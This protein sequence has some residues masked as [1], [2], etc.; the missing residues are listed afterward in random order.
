M[1]SP[2]FFDEFVPRVRYLCDQIYSQPDVDSRKKYYSL[3]LS[4][5]ESLVQ[6]VASE[7]QQ[8]EEATAAASS[9]NTQDLF[10]EF[11]ESLPQTFVGDDYVVSS[12]DSTIDPLR[13]YGSG[14]ENPQVP[15][16]GVAASRHQAHSAPPDVS[17]YTT[18]PMPTTASKPLPQASAQ[19]REGVTSST[20]DEA[21]DISMG[22]VPPSASAPIL[23]ISSSG[24]PGPS[25]SHTGL[26][27]ASASKTEANDCCEICGY[28][29][30]GDPQW[31]KGSMAKHKKL[32]HSTDPPV[33][34]RCPFPGCTSAYKN[35]QDN[36]RQHQLEKGHFVGDEA[37]SRR[38]SKRKKV[39]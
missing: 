14:P 18:S 4:L 26:P 30:K 20:Q 10:D 11:I 16:M 7:P 37:A 23:P 24:L 25:T 21:D 3:G 1:S 15:S 34:Y 39:S 9:S 22:G 32:Q 17:S 8:N 29:P 33:I 27:P 6:S 12:L 2:Y 28:R 38:P 36:L 19:L 13:F 5:V 31:F 35:R